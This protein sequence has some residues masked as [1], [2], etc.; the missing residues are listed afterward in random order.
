MPPS[1]ASARRPKIVPA[2]TYAKAYLESPAVGGSRTE[3]VLA[4]MF[5]PCS[6]RGIRNVDAGVVYKTGCRDFQKSEGGFEVPAGR[7]AE[8]F[9]SGGAGGECAAP[10]AAKKFSGMP[11]G[12]RADAVFARHGFIVLST[13]G[14]NQSNQKENH[15]LSAAMFSKQ[16]K[17]SNA[18]ASAAS[19]FWKSPRKFK[20]V[21]T[22]TAGA[23][24]P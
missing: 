6:R 10:D 20:L 5:A 22:I 14:N 3:G 23:P 7:W 11:D 21:S 13:A 19:S 1:S 9:L 2:G 16:N 18:A 4:K 8:D 12:Q 15:E 24:P 17:T